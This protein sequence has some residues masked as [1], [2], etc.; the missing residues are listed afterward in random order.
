M[1]NNFYFQFF[2]KNK[3]YVYFSRFLPEK[4]IKSQNKINMIIYLIVN[5]Q[6][7]CIFNDKKMQE[8]WRQESCILN[9][10][11]S[12]MVTMATKKTIWW[13]QF[14]ILSLYSEFL[15]Y[16]L[17]EIWSNFYFQFLRYQLRSYALKKTLNPCFWS[18]CILYI[19]HETMTLYIVYLA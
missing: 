11:F 14:F 15:K 17:C 9:F 8:L 10:Y 16:P 5:K 1:W 2:M 3:I 6:S 4:P 13:L 7:Q 19:F 12:E 18:A